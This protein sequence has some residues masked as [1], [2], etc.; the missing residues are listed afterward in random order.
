MTAVEMSM[1]GVAPATRTGHN[2]WAGVSGVV[3]GPLL[4]VSVLSTAGLP[5]ADKAAKVQAWTEKHTSLLTGAALLS[6][7]GVII[8][9]YFLT[10]AH[11][12]LSGRESSWMGTMFLVGI[13]I[14]GVA[15]TVSAGLN[16]T[17]GADGKHLTTGSL[18]LMASLE[19]NLN[20]GMTCIGLA[21]LFFAAGHL[22]RRSGLLPGW[23]AWASWTFAV[24]AA[25][26]V[27]GIIALLGMVL[28]SIVVGVLFT[29]RQPVES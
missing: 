6:V 23:L 4:V 1:S 9:L 14:F 13:V 21:I 12:I 10:W 18:Q 29:M 15:G 2:R 17:L 27:L 26:V 11:S 5:H 28:W 20:Y 16:A 7:A 8:G 22:I 24:L 19:E 3:F 25:T